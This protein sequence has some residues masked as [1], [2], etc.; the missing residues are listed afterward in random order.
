MDSDDCGSDSLG[1]PTMVAADPSPAT[2][3]EIRR[4]REQEERDEALYLDEAPATGIMVPRFLVGPVA[5]SL[6]V[7]AIGLL[8]L[9]VIG[10]VASTVATLSALPQWA[11]MVFCVALV[12]VAG[13]TLFALWKVAAAFMSLRRNRQIQ[14][15]GLQELAARQTGRRQANRKAEEGRS[16]AQRYTEA[17]P[18]APKLT[19]VGFGDEDIKELEAVRQRLM[20]DSRASGAQDWLEEFRNDFQGVLDRVANG[21]I[22]YYARRVGL[23]TA[24][25]PNALIDTL[26]ALYCAFMMLSSL[27]RIY[28]L[29]LGGMGTTVLLVRAFFNAYLAGQTNELEDL[30]GENIQH[31][32]GLSEGLWGA[33]VGKVGAKA[34]TG[35]LNYFLLCRLGKHAVKL[36]RPVAVDYRER[37]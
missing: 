2:N 24:A 13:A 20:D 17:Y 15:K 29:R 26:V 9:F 10:Q 16:T 3:D 21:R 1:I 32:L 25:S 22:Q 7:A 18:I 19:Q 6:L 30:A 27:A 33:I 12:A 31:A 37:S 11:Q 23:K 4:L 14:L 8:V 36:L 5:I 28:N 34:A 35:S